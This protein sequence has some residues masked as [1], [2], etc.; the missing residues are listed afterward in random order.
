[1]AYNQRR[2][3]FL[4]VSTSA[5]GLCAFGAGRLGALEELP[6]QDRHVRGVCEMCS[7]RCPMEAHVVDGKVR[8][9]EGNHYDALQGSALCARGVAGISQLYDKERLVKPLIRVG[10]RGENR[11]R[12]AS[13]EEAFEFVSHAMNGIKKRYGA[14]SVIFSAKNGEHF[15]QM[16]YFASAFGSPNTFSHWSSCPIA[17]ETAMHH[18][19]GMKMHRDMEHAQYILNFGHNLFEG[20]D[21]ALTKPL[22]ALAADAGRKL[23]VLD[24]RFSVIAAKAD[25]WYP[26]APGS[27]L[28]FVLALIHVWIRDEKYDKAFVKAFS[29]GF[30]HLVNS[31]KETTPQWQKSFTGIDTEVVERIANELWRAAPKC[32]I[33]W[34]H[35]ST[36]T[37]AE[38]QRSRAIMIA[39]VLMGNVEKEGGIFFAKEAKWI[40]AFVGKKVVPE[41][42][43]RPFSFQKVPVSRLDKVGTEDKY[44]FVPH[45]HGI[46]QAIPQAIL[47]QHPYPIKGWVL[48]RH[49]PLV[50]VANPQ[51][52]KQAMAALELIV[53][54]DIYMSETAM[55]ADVVFP[56]ATYL[57]RESGIFNTSLKRPSYSMRNGSVEPIGGTMGVIELFAKLALHVGCYAPYTWKNASEYRLAQTQGDYKLISEL[58]FKGVYTAPIPPLLC[59]E[60]TYVENFIEKFPHLVQKKDVQGFFSSPL[61]QFKTPSGKI[62]IF[63]QTIEDVLAEYGVPRAVDMDVRQGY[64]Y[65][66]SS[67]KTAL[68]TNGHTHNVPA[69]KM[70]MSENPVWMH[71]QTAKEHGLKQGDFCY[72]KNS[73]DTL[74][75]KVF[76]TEGIRPDTL[77]AYMGF[78]RETSNSGKEKGINPSKLLSLEIAP[79][80]G[81]MITNIGVYIL[82][83][84]DA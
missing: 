63:S 34:G 24:P 57:E 27:D 15:D 80:C 25:E 16:R 30:E 21:I 13:Y 47:E 19:F 41:V 78:G 53:V 76:I 65:V 8:F 56:E 22:A 28:A 70:M 4:H 83:E 49:N 20:I 72:L 48:S 3:D 50:T 79:V 66:F 51:K 10:E 2:R 68:H 31:T 44:R 9:I 60:K 84:K 55:M 6:S 71:P 18:T 58:S 74:K 52:M 36:T 32:I 5:L 7:S 17:I 62:E 12:E 43:T 38:Y 73:V 67:G 54:N 59:L 75:T 35:K 37:K 14:Q 64:P 77:F 81:S 46:L 33:D 1:M 40:N 61:H 69:L 26:I 11:W 42:Q 39:N 23:V 29:V 45:A 82:K